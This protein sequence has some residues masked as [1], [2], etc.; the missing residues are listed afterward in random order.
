MHPKWAESML[1]LCWKYLSNVVFWAY[2][3]VSVCAGLFSLGTPLFTGM[4]VNQ[5]AAG[6][7][8]WME[9]IGIL[10]FSLLSL[11][12]CQAALA[13]LSEML[14]VN[15]QSHAGYRLNLDTLEHIKRLP[16]S[17]F[18]RFDATYYT[19]QINHDANDLVIFVLE[20]MVQIVSNIAVL[21]TVFIILLT[22]NV[23]LGFACA[24]LAVLAGFLYRVF[25]RSLFKKSFDMQ[26]RSASF[27]SKLQEQL[28]KVTF[29][30]RHALFERFEKGL[31]HAFDGLYPAIRSN[32]KVSAGFALSNSIAGSVAHG[33]LLVSGA[34]EVAG[35]RLQPGYLV[36]AIGYYESLSA[37]VQYFLAWGKDYQASRVSYERLRRIW[38]IQEERNGKARLDSVSRIDCEGIGLSYPGSEKIALG[39]QDFHFQRGKLYGIAGANGA[40]KSTLL[41][42]LLGMYPDE[43]VGSVLYD[44]ISQHEIDRYALR[45]KCVGLTEQEPP[46]LDDTIE[47]N[48]TLLS[49]D[50][51]AN[52]LDGYI[53]ELGLREMVSAAPSGLGTVLNRRGHSISG[54]E[55]QKIAIVRLLLKD[56]T[57]MLF[58]EPTSALDSSSRRSLMRI[59]QK[60]KS[61]HIL[62]VVTHDE[63]LLSA[64]DEIYWL[65]GGRIS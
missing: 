15:L 10:C 64:C 22:L 52:D 20:S 38:D 36:T 56:S 51:D 34:I 58:D 46:I 9:R 11:Q 21:I 45:A 17:F 8:I 35:G 1:R 41:D 12:V 29:L 62:I 54:G 19:Q 6:G 4:I 37:A 55:K 63:E 16:Q 14:Y 39:A 5:L 26:E 32:Q 24:F 44:G 23:R 40:G 42:I 48:L 25:R 28:D 18:A 49:S 57:V 50:W 60:K 53:D 30:R 65:N 43:T 27:F 2:L 47:A 3:A 13:Y 61:D 31:S 59:L 33:L 7:G